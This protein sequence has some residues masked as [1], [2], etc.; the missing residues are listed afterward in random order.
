MKQFVDHFK[1]EI[2]GVEVLELF[3]HLTVNG[4]EV[5][6]FLLQLE[7][8]AD[9]GLELVSL[10]LDLVEVSICLA[11]QEVEEAKVFKLSHAVFDQLL[12]N[13]LLV[14][15][16][17]EL[18]GGLSKKLSVGVEFL[19][20][21]SVLAGKK[22][23][24]LVEDIVVHS[25]SYSLQRMLHNINVAC[26]SFFLAHGILDILVVVLPP[27]IVV[28]F[29]IRLPQDGIVKQSPLEGFVWVKVALLCC[30]GLLIL[31]HLLVG[32]LDQPDLVDVDLNFIFEV[33]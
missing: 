21:D 33:L 10:V 20:L 32:V 11:L 25:L 3:G 24:V 29:F 8:A 15:T 6:S 18:V 16:E 14:D 27:L 7:S 9:E 1:H 4:I 13:H 17:L 23:H 31:K 28:S 5:H 30:R 26:V 22:L 12:W 2:L 19:K